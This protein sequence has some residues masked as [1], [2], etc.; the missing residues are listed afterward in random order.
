VINRT[1]VSQ[2][3]NLLEFRIEEIGSDHLWGH[4][5][6]GDMLKGMPVFAGV[7]SCACPHNIRGSPGT[8]TSGPW[9]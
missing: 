7:M 8:P 3:E 2:G 6:Y 4:E 5:Y 1:L 9:A